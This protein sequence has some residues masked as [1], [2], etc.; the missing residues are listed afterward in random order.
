MLQLTAGQSL[1]R[2]QPKYC[3]SCTSSM[4]GAVRH[5]QQ[6]STEDLT[7]CCR[8]GSS[9]EA[10]L[11]TAIRTSVL[12]GRHSAGRSADP[13]CMSCYEQARC[14]GAKQVHPRTTSSE[15]C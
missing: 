4:Q 8:V 9:S 13:A 7:A 12:Q 5:C 15:C 3:C 14:R 6:A 1:S 10:A 2:V 11:G